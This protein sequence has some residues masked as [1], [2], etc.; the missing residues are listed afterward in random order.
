ME[1][2]GKPFRA[3]GARAEEYVAAMRMLWTTDPATF[4]GEWVRF[5]GAS[6]HPKPAQRPHPPIWIGGSWRH[7][8]LRALRGSRS[9]WL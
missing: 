8:A 2:L 6:F 7:S 5:A 9:R 1:W 3:R 4:E